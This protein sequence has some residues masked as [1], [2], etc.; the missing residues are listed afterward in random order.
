MKKF[1]RKLNCFC[2]LL[3][4]VMVFAQ[5]T[6]KKSAV[7]ALGNPIT[8]VQQGDNI[9]Y[10]VE[11]SNTAATSPASTVSLRDTADPFQSYIPGSIQ[12]PNGWTSANPTVG[13][14]SSK[15]MATW[16]PSTLPGSYGANM[17]PIYGTNSFGGQVPIG[18]NSNISVTGS[19]DGFDPIT[20]RFPNGNLAVATINH[21]RTTANVLCGEFAN[22]GAN[23][24][25]NY[26]NDNTIAS[27][28]TGAGSTGFSWRWAIAGNRIFFPLNAFGVTGITANTPGIGCLDFSNNKLEECYIGT[29][30][31]V[32]KSQ[33]YFQATAAGATD[34]TQYVGVVNKAGKICT[35]WAN[36]NNTSASARRNELRVGCVD[37]LTMDIVSDE[38]IVVS[39]A[40]ALL[41]NS[42]VGISVNN[43][44][45]GAGE[46]HNNVVEQLPGDNWAVSFRQN[47]R[48]ATAPATTI[49]E[50]AFICLKSNPGSG[51]TTNCDGTPI[52]YL[53]SVRVA[54]NTNGTNATTNVPGNYTGQGMG[55]LPSL[56][57]TGNVNGVCVEF[58]DRQCYDTNG[59]IIPGKLASTSLVFPG[60]SS[61]YDVVGL[62][63]PYLLTYTW[64]WADTSYCFDWSTNALCAN[65][66]PFDANSA[67]G[68]K[69]FIEQGNMCLVTY[70]HNAV[71]NMF[72][73]DKTATGGQF[74]SGGCILNYTPTQRFKI[75]DPSANFCNP[76]TNITK[77]TTVDLKRLPIQSGSVLNFYSSTGTLIATAPVPAT[78]TANST[79]TVTIPAAV[80]Y[81]LYP[82]LDIE[83]DLNGVNAT[84]TSNAELYTNYQTNDGS[85][86]Q[87]CYDVSIANCPT[88]RQSTNSVS[89]SGGSTGT[90][91]INN[92]NQ[93]LTCS[94][95]DADGDGIS[96]INDVDDDN[97]GILDSVES[98]CL[99]NVAVT[100]PNPTA[101]VTNGGLSIYISENSLTT[102]TITDSGVGFTGL[103]PSQ[104]AMFTYNF[105]PLVNNL[106]LWFADLDNRE[107]LKINYYDKNGNRI[108]NVLPY[109]TNDVGATKNLSYD[110][111]YGLL[112]DPTNN[113][114]GGSNASS[115][116]VE[117]TIPFATSKV[118][119]TFN[120]TRKDGTAY[121]A[122]SSTPEVYI[123]G[124]CS[125]VDTDSDGIP[126][127]L[128]LDSD[129]DGCS[130][131]REGSANIQNSQLVTA[132]G[133]VSGG[134]T[135]VNQNLCALT[136]C[137]STLGANIGLPQF[138]TLPTGYSNATGQGVGN[139]QSKLRNDCIDS[140]LDGIADW[141][142]IDDDNDGIGD[143]VEMGSCTTP[144]IVSN[145]YMQD[146][147]TL[148]A[149][150]IRAFGVSGYEG[151]SGLS[152]KT[153]NPTSDLNYSL[154][155][156]P[157]LVDDFGGIYNNQWVHLGDH[158]GNANGLMLL[159]NPFPNA[160]SV[161]QSPTIDVNI[162]AGLQASFWVLNLKEPTAVGFDLPRLKLE[163]F[164]AATNA[165]IG[166]V[167]TGTIA[168]TGV[169][170]NISLALPLNTIASGIYI[171]M[172]SIANSSNGSDF[173][174]DDIKVDEIYCDT[175]GDGIPNH[176]DLDS[177]GDGCSDA[178][179]GGANI[180]T[181]QLVTAAGTVSGG[182]TTVNQ[183]LCALTTCV[184][185]TGSNIGL[186]QFTT[187][188]TGY[189]NTTGQTVGNSLDSSKNDCVDSDA[190]GIPDWQDI[191]DDNDGILDTNEVLFCDQN[192]PPNGTFPTGT[193]TPRPFEKQLLFFDWSGVTLSNALPSATR[194]VLFNGVTYTATITGFNST[195][196]FT[197]IGSDINTFNGPSQ[198]IKNYYNVNGATFKEVFY[199]LSNE[200]TI[201]T[202]NIKIT[203]NRGSLE[204]PVEV[205]VFDPETTNSSNPESL[206][207]K[208][209]GSNFSLLQQTGTG[210]INS[211][212]ISGDGTT[213]LTY[214]DTQ[215][216][217]VNAIYVT[218]G[219][220]PNI[221]ATVNMNNVSGARQAIGF[222]VRVFCDNDNDGVPNFLDL[223][224]DGDGCSDAIEGGADITASQLVA[225]AGIVSGGSTTVNQNL[226]A[227]TTCVSTT[228]SNIGLPQFT[229]LPT[230]YNNTTGQTIGSSQDNSVNNC[231]CFKPGIS[232]A[233]NTYPTKHG[234][235][236]LGRAG[237]DNENWPMTRQS[238][239]TVLESKEK[240]FVVNRVATT[241][242]LAN[243]TNPVE[244]MMVYD[245]QA[246]CLKIYTL[247][248]GDSGMA[249]HCFTTPACPD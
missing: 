77:W 78:T 165:S 104:G 73:I 118:E 139:S 157:D 141:Q 198:M 3:M 217:N 10:V 11:V 191:D 195:G 172:T 79:A 44:S 115:Q 130:D 223:D 122:T 226:C 71:W 123:K 39:P 29:S 192:N 27:Y 179:E 31:R 72:S 34:Y 111:A 232:D 49:T 81:A 32:R 215:N 125:D 65:T 63:K 75:T 174:I 248:T 24:L 220:S 55:I 199:N 26:L 243:I 85:K 211:S 91:N 227:L 108:A 88:N 175:D 142:D 144:S 235:T 185:T 228:G 42:A 233:G 103:Q 120:A 193:N 70:G 96:D 69:A 35:V 196:G 58:G 9:K 197:M 113:A 159:A 131:A 209:S 247:K 45:F 176:L 119:V 230:G 134:S 7:D 178:I 25:G 202:L 147:G 221:T 2:A 28:D 143:S 74:T 86:P 239:W 107:Y 83:L 40:S 60:N 169:W 101:T 67:Y 124:L 242:G 80:D 182:S 189:S 50:N 46:S 109:V 105:S 203:A 36:A 116:Y 112:I 201:N 212:N 92:T 52:T 20:F 229:T 12:V 4:T 121:T 170:Q 87:I 17:A 241:A 90:A 234:I 15:L 54:K 249:W 216:S 30:P 210:T 167:N 213:T 97:D 164:N 150:G 84:A 57:A 162:G 153:T 173:A 98:P 128:D 156:N 23:C 18:T 89:V 219:Y 151:T 245:E 61:S 136:T 161:W 64:S 177:D 163:V 48:L 41:A 158:T 94:I 137:V 146:F 149:P 166:F 56:D 16:N 168:Q 95:D 183:N 1:N 133:T 93:Y 246:D 76:A 244:G 200:K 214:L 222:A 152:Y 224:S 99:S 240:G 160:T 6:L 208:T 37:P 22:G 231:F 33:T 117:V 8:T 236:A 68:S 181:P 135:T 148:T 106:K 145:L 62:G 238:A 13:P 102:S 5:S 188:P 129:A 114:G 14:L 21:H 110:A 171:R 194:S 38:T 132:A 187:L 138:T 140:D 19:G 184:S 180:T 82:T 53:T 154:V 186:P 218:S 66:T 51:A 205:A 126:D 43:S 207:Y 59:T 225:A 127:Y 190:D 206:I 204:L 155:T 100:D 237:A 47:Y